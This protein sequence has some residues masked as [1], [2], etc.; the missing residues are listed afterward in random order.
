MEYKI[1]DRVRV[2]DYCNIADENKS[3][4]VGMN[5]G[6]EGIIVDKLMSEKWGGC[7]Y[8]VQFD[9]YDRPSKTKFLADSLER[10]EKPTYTI[11]LECLDNVVVA[12]MIEVSATSA[13]EVNRAH[14]HIIHGGAFG[15]A[16][17]A[18]Y[19][20]KRICEN[21]NGSPFTRRTVNYESSKNGGVVNDR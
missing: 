6:K 2:K 5:C 19:A 15:V 3:K 10:L 9:G 1:G 14:G 7:V 20:L 16:Q 17:A 12:R 21:I 4:K 13:A 18:S 8:E 11:T